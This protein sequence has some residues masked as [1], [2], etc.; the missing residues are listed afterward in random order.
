MTPYAAVRDAAGLVRFS[1]TVFALPFAL[2]A[3]LAA[4]HGLPAPATVAWIIVAM[5]GART[6]AMAF[7][8]IADR[9][10]DAVNPRTAARHLPAGRVSPAFAW[11]LVGGGSALVLIAAWRLN[12]LCLALAPLALAWLLAYSFTKRFTALSHLWLGL[13]L[14]LAPVGAWLAVR[15]RFDVAPLILAAAVT[16]WVGGFDVLYSLQDEAFDRRIGLFSL[17][18][19]IGATRAILVARL[20]H[21]GA[22][23]GF[24]AFAWTIHAGVGLWIGVAAAAILLIWQ[25]SLVAPG[26]LERLDT[27]FFTANGTLSLAML[28]LYVLDMMRSG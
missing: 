21:A 18:A 28:A 11:S 2:I 22:A 19:R 27:A 25:H 10:F 8:R 14:G 24:A 17:P 9:R 7:N 16:G 20:F 3:M 1:H 26:R 6:A 12:P 23:I 15:G 4:T 13:S 5:I